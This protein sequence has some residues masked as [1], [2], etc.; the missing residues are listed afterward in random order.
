MTQVADAQAMFDKIAK[1]HRVVTGEIGEM[2]IELMSAPL[3]DEAKERLD[4]LRKELDDERHKFTDAAI[5][6][7]KE[8]TALE[9]GSSST[10]QLLFVVYS[11]LLIGGTFQI[12]R[13]KAFL[14]SRPDAC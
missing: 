6:F 1:D 13:R 7:G 3:Q 9:V 2:N 12:P 14:A 4:A 11:N 8:K 5:R 10:S